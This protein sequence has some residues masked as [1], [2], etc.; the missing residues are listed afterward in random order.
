MSCRLSRARFL[1]EVPVA[2]LCNPTLAGTSGAAPQTDRDFPSSF[3]WETPQ[4]LHNFTEANRNVEKPH[5]LRVGLH[6]MT[7]C[8]SPGAFVQCALRAGSCSK[9]FLTAVSLLTP[10]S[11]QDAAQVFTD[12]KTEAVHLGS[13]GTLGC[14]L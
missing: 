3:F 6:V 10:H 5:E 4:P 7:P 8:V 14:Q 2:F 1:P 13:G 9:C 11:A 12:E